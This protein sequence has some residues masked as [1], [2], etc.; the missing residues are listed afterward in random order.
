[1]KAHRITLSTLALALMLP[2]T[3]MAAEKIPANVTTEKGG[4]VSAKGDAAVV[5]DLITVTATVKSVDMATRMVTLT[6]T[7]NK[8]FAIKADD[9]VKNLAQVRAGDKVMIEFY[10][11]IAAELVQP[12]ATAKAAGVAEGAIVAAPGERPGGAAAKVV[13]KTVVIDFIDK[14]RNTV[15]FHDAN[16]AGDH[17][18]VV[19]VKKPEMRKMLKTLK[20][21]D[22][23]TVSFFEAVAI[24]VKPVAK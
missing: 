3:A 5:V 24:T 22:K 21:G 1:M 13:T 15:Q 16:V 6:G 4:M 12:G 10:E 7:D 9:A 23:V 18:R 11:G 14:V 8:T 17:S 19:A 20:V 2:A